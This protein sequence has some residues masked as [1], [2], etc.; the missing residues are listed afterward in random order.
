MESI[1]KETKPEN[2]NTDGITVEKRTVNVNGVEGTAEQKDVV[3]EERKAEAKTSAPEPKKSSKLPLIITLSV[4]V[5]AGLIFLF[6][7][8][9]AATTGLIRDI[10]LII[11]VIESI[12]ALIAFVVMSTRLAQLF[13]FL[14]Y[15]LKPILNNTQKT[16]KRFSGTVS[17]LCDN[18]VEPTITAA[19]KV[20]GFQNA[21][22]GVLGIFKKL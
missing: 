14:K 20:S 5:I 6:C 19:A 7:K 3:I 8:L 1:N 21:V 22:N 16:V 10:A 18:A 12:V 11:F 9:P 2:A 4:L 17:F 13:N 15:E